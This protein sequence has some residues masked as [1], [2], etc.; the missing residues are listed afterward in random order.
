MLVLENAHGKGSNYFGIMYELTN[1]YKV[2]GGEEED[3]AIYLLGKERERIIGRPSHPK[4]NKRG[5]DYQQLF[6]KH[7]CTDVCILACLCTYVPLYGT[8]PMPWSQSVRASEAQPTLTFIIIAHLRSQD[9][10]P[11][12]LP[13]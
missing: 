4:E 7:A 8:Q 12:R 6:C 1:Y 9:L 2:V 10:C 5:N 11:L 3:K 13:P